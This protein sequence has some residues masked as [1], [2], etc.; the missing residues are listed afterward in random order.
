M[1][2]IGSSQPR[3]VQDVQA[4]P[5]F[6]PNPLLPETRAECV[7][8]MLAGRTVVGALELK[9]ATPNAF[10][11]EVISLLQ[12]IGAL[13]AVAVQNVRL[14]ESEF[15][16][17]LL[18]ETL[19]EVGQLLS[20]TLNQ[21]EVLMR[22]L[23]QLARAVPYDRAAVLLQAKSAKQRKSETRR[24]QVGNGRVRRGRHRQLR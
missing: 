11:P 10:S 15:S 21:D 6:A 24:G 2:G 5:G 16:R 22:L 14:Y 20:S 17:R 12:G 7:I 23:G 4:M 18:A 19:Q 3:V 9:S 13:L 1:P 8:P